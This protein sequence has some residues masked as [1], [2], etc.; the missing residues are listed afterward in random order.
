MAVDDPAA[1]R[2]QPRRVVAERGQRLGRLPHEQGLVG[3]RRPGD[4][5]EPLDRVHRSRRYPGWIGPTRARVQRSVST[6]VVGAARSRD[7][8]P[9]HTRCS[10]GSATHSTLARI[11]EGEVAHAHGR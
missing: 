8:V 6:R 1:G 7:D 5:A 10:P 9:A 2:H 3:A 4:V 11:P